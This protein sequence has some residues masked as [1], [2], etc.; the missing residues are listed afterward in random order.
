MLSASAR[1]GLILVLTAIVGFACAPGAQTPSTSSSGTVHGGTVTIIGTW[2]GNEL[3]SFNAVLKPFEDKT[4]ISVQFE[5]TRDL[6]AILTTR[7]SAG[8]PPDLAAVPG[9]QLLNQF[10]QQNKLVDLGKVL[11]TNK[12]KSEYAKGWIDLGTV[13]GKLV[14]VFSWAAV[15]GLVWYN[16]KVFQAKGYTVPKTWNDM[17]ALQNKIK[18]DGTTPWCMTVESGSASGWAGSDFHKE[19]AL[20]QSGPDVY[21][22]W[23]QGKQKWTSSQIKQAWTTFGQVLGPND[24][25]VYGGANYIVNTN[26]GDVGN[27]MF[28]ASPPKCNLINQASF[29]TDF[30]VKANP[31]IKAGQDFNFFPLPDVNTKY[32]GAHVVAADAWS[33]FK[34]TPQTRALLQY[35]VTAEAQAIWVKRGGKLSPNNKTNPSDYPDD[36]SRATAKILL[37]TKIAKYDAGDQM[38]PAMQAAYWSAILDFIKDQSKLDSI[39]SNLDK[40]QASAYSS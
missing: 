22:K 30:F 32:A 1:R 9:P 33:M 3:D 23:W 8:D 16:P 6:A 13:N 15:K 11:D 12:L 29:I 38:P 25:N 37:D 2:T 5:G 28:G 36:I 20:S 14:E 19:I 27:P 21:D 34:D 10:A 39:L 35:L 40:V 4:G 18:A 7:V 17:M 24:A 31:S 26:F